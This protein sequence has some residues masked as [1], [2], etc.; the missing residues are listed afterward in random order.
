M[1]IVLNAIGAPTSD[2]G[3]LFAVDWLVDR[4]RTTNNLLGDLYATVFVEHFSQ[5]E[6][7]TMDLNS[8]SQNHTSAYPTKILSNGKGA[9][10]DE[11][12]GLPSPV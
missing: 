11:F 7:K 8:Y 5:E 1:F 6:L 12:N 4:I 9:S 10:Y 2:I 3:L